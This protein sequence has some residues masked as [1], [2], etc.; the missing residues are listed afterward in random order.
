MI[1]CEIKSDDAGKS[2][3]AAIPEN[4]EYYHIEENGGYELR[5]VMTRQ[6]WRN[7]NWLLVPHSRRN[8]LSP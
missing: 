2:V 8:E 3:M 4:Y 1:L 7:H 5:S 6:V